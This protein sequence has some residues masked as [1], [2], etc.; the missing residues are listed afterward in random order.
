MFSKEYFKYLFRSKKYL[1]LLIALITLMNVIGNQ[2]DGI[3][4]L[5]QVFFTMV[6]SFAMPMDVFYHVHNRKAVD[7]YFSIPVSRKALMVTGCVF[8]ALVTFFPAACAII[9]NTLGDRDISTLLLLA[10]TLLDCASVTVFNS[11]LYLIGNNIIDGVVMMG[12]YTFM[13]LA[14]IGI[15]NS[16][17]YSYIAGLRSIE[18]FEARLLSPLY[19]GF[20][21]LDSSWNGNIDYLSLIGLI[22]VLILFSYLLY[23][24]YVK[25]AA[26]RADSQSTQF[27]SYPFVINFYLISCLFLIASFYNYNYGNLGI[28][29]KDYFFLYVLLFAVF[30]AAY[31]LYRRKFYFNYRL[32][33]F[34]VIVMLIS[35]LCAGVCMKY[36]GFGLSGCYEK[37]KGKDYCTISAWV[38]YH[39]GIYEYVKEETGEDPQYVQIFIEV[40][41]DD[42]S[43]HPAMSEKTSDLIEEIRKKAIDYFY[44]DRDDLSD[45]GVLYISG[46]DSRKYYQYDLNEGL[47]LQTIVEFA[48]D[49]AVTVMIGTYNKEYQLM[50]DGSLRVS[51]VYEQ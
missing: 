29:V 9:R 3:M 2:S 43:F 12:A 18:F 37:A 38:D 23:R 45:I 46:K 13:P 41:G 5:I 50:T 21:L 26:E 28:F 32:P 49:P 7:T 20:Y 48:K 34:Y 8:S 33:L 36:D 30:V 16:F 19:M 35:L 27:L 11:V 31:F 14:I 25:R 1:L 22:V 40:G 15:L 44:D 39:N 24:S 17:V 10:E 51:Q 4:L 6:L 42:A 47:D